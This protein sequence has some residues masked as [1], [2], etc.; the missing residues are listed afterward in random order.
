MTT[1]GWGEGAFPVG[2]TQTSISNSKDYNALLHKFH[3][4]THAFLNYKPIQWHT[5]WWQVL[6]KTAASQMI[7]TILWNSPIILVK[8]QEVGAWHGSHFPLECGIT[9]KVSNNHVVIRAECTAWIRCAALLTSATCCKWVFLNFLL[10]PLQALYNINV[11]SW[12]LHR[13]I[14]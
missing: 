1:P 5:W 13:A 14:W 8:L 2:R 10:L 11:I 7:I 12:N 6:F 9:P 4:V 3:T